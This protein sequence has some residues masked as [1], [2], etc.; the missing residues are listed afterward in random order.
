MKDIIYFANYG[1]N[2]RTIEI[3]RFAKLKDALAF[4]Q[5]KDGYITRL[6]YIDDKTGYSTRAD[7]FTEKLDCRTHGFTPS[8]S[9]LNKLS[10]ILKLSRE[11]VLIVWKKAQYII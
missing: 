8:A 7:S 11:Q 4:M 5:D 3:E 10:N 6:E 2:E 1:N 9:E